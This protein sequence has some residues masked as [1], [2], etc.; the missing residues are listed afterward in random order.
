MSSE[1]VDEEE[2]DLYTH[3]TEG[4][5]RLSKGHKKT[6]LIMKATRTTQTVF[7]RVV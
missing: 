4:N 1:D 6:L 7:Q 5:N 2:T 3:A